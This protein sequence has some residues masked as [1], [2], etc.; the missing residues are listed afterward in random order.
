MGRGAIVSAGRLARRGHKTPGMSTPDEP[1]LQPDSLV[2]AAGRPRDAGAPVNEPVS[3]SSTYRAGGERAYAREG[4]PAW[5]AFEEVL[6]QLELGC[7][8]A[9]ASG[10]AAAAA[11]LETLPERARVAV[12]GVAYHGVHELVRDRAAA[13]RLAVEFLDPTQSESHAAACEGAGLVWLETPT[14]PMLEVVDISAACAAAQAAG[15]LVV[16]DNTFATP[17]RQRPLELGAHVVLHSA[18]KFL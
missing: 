14:N 17:L 8:V 5:S 13:G 2:V 3:F 1:R 18:T 6:G 9:F 11:L 15:A 10:M 7:C 12:S 16:V 4:N